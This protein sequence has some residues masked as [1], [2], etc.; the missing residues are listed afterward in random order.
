MKYYYV[1]KENGYF[2]DVSECKELANAFS[3]EECMTK[4]CE[5]LCCTEEEVDLSMVFEVKQGGITNKWCIE[6]S[7]VE[8]DLVTAMDNFEF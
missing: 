5:V 8:G 7:V 2:F 6:N 4:V 3:D 1:S